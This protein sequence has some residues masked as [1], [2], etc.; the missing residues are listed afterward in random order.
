MHWQRCSRSASQHGKRE[1]TPPGNL[2]PWVACATHVVVPVNERSLGV[3]P[4]GPDVQFEERV[5]GEA[6]RGVDESEDL[7]LQNR[8]SGMSLQPGGRVGNELDADQFHL[9]IRW[10]VDQCLWG[11]DINGPVE[12]TRL[13]VVDAHGAMI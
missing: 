4:P 9:A 12:Q 2:F 1:Q 7:T 13:D 10:L 6:V 5:Y 11:G 8:W 3:V